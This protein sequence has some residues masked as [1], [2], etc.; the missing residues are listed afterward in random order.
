[1]E[2]SF[3]VKIAEKYGLKEAVMLKN[4]VLWCLKN[5]ANNVNYNDGF[6]WTYNSN[7]EFSELFPFWTEKQIRSILISLEEKGLIVSGNYNKSSYDR[8]KWYAATNKAYSET[9]NYILPDEKIHLTARKKNQ[10]SS[11]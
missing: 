11:N 1:M 2:Y 7:R 10:S 8:T 4:I 3:D 6:Y 9:G 5:R